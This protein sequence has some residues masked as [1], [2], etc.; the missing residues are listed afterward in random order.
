MT[1]EKR[2]GL[3]EATRVAEALRDILEPHCERFAIAGSV[4]R[5][6]LFVKDIEIVYIPKLVAPADLFGETM[7]SAMDVKLDSLVE[8]G[9]L[10][11][12]RLNVRGSPTYGPV[13]K[14]LTHVPT[15]IGVDVF[16]TVAVAARTE[17]A[18]RQNL[19]RVLAK[20]PPGRRIVE[21]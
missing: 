2:W 15:G 9:D 6:K 21:E 18:A 17:Q 20:G 4:R 7:V 12:K 13:N 14:L 5:N 8:R 1:E 19:E 11:K 16:A 10:L 3:A